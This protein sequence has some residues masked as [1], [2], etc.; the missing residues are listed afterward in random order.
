METSLI[1]DKIKFLLMIKLLEDMAISAA[2]QI[3]RL[4]LL[5]LILT[6]VFGTFLMKSK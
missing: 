4:F 2:Q 6:V 3:I 1:G 5:L